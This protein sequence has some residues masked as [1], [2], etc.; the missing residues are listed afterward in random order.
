MRKL[1]YRGLLTIA[2]LSNVVVMAGKREVQQLINQYYKEG[3]LN[4][5]V[6]VAQGGKVVCDTVVGLSKKEKK[7]KNTKQTLFY[8]ASIT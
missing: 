3:K 7:V 8:G 2:L 5:A 1:I 6:L 4:G